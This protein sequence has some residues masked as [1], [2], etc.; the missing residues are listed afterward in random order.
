LKKGGRA[1]TLRTVLDDRSYMRDLT[2]RSYSAAMILLWVNVGV[3]ILQEINRTYIHSFAEIYCM[4][5][6]AGIAKGYVWQLF[7][8][9]FMHADLWHLLGNGLGLFFLGRAVEG[10]IG[11]RRFLQAY[12][13][14]GTLGGI[15]QVILGFR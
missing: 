2:P 10:M 9:Q 6:P 15:F 7:T 3:F 13:L 1:I 14:A 8:F 11:T 4:L 12:F 5:S